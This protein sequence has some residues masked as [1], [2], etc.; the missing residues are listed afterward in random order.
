[1][2]VYLPVFARTGMAEIASGRMPPNI[3]DAYVMLKPESDR[4]S[5]IVVRL[6]ENLRDGGASLDNA[7]RDGALTRLQPLLMTV[8]YRMAHGR[9]EEFQGAASHRGPRS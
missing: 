9:E 5:D 2:I 4:R 3:S 6:P 7:I 8:R 1:M